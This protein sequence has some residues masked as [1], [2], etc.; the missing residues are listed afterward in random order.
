VRVPRAQVSGGGHVNDYDVLAR[1]DAALPADY[2]RIVAETAIGTVPT[3]PYLDLSLT[4]ELKT[5][6]LA[7]IKRLVESGAFTN[8]PQVENFERDFAAYCDAAHCVGVASGLD[9]LRLALLAAGLEP[10]EEVVVPALTFAATLEAV[11]QT[12]GVPVIA[13]I[14]EVDYCLDLEAAASAVSPRT[15]FLLPVHLYGQ[16]ADLTL[17]ETLG[18]PI[19]EDA[20]QA[21]GAR[22]DG[23]NAGST[24]HAAAFSFYPTKNLGAFGDAG[25]LT[26]SDEEVAATVR[27]LREHGQFRKYEHELEGYTARLDTIQAVVLLHKLPLLEAWNERRRRAAAFYTERLAGVGD[28]RLPQV[29]AGSEPVWHL[30]V[31]RTRRPDELAGFL[32]ERGVQ[33]GRHYPQ[34]LHLAPA[35]A[36]LGYRKGAFPV[37]EALARK[38]LSL[39]LFPGI[40][41]AQ[42]AAVVEGI[43]A[44]FR[45]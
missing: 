20:C 1:L 3:I 18:L 41:E 4:P 5:E 26:T 6:I 13:D 14:G 21:H 7:E 30:Y 28:L 2:P 16:M 25:A 12:G 23:C 33:T 10:G 31:V 24:G 44:Y 11:T 22:R 17:L 35:Y 37:A 42:L 27:A 19:I 32:R 29:P 39:P 9:A 40:S 43:D 45:G 15:R 38:C 34:P 8:G 36:H